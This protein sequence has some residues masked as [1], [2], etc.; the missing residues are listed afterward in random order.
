MGSGFIGFNH[1]YVA[2]Q[3]VLS[4]GCA[5]WMFEKSPL[6]RVV[7]C[8]LLLVGTFATG[9]RGGFIVALI[10]VSLCE[11]RQTKNSSIVLVLFVTLGV[12]GLATS[13]EF[14]GSLDRQKSATN[15][16]QDDGLSGRTDIW[17]EHIDYFRSNPLNLFVG[18]GFGFGEKVSESNAHNLYLQVATESGI[19]GLIIFIYLQVNT[20]RHLGGEHFKTIRITVWMLL[21][22]GLTQDTLYPVPAFSQFIGFYLSTLIVTF[23]IAQVQLEQTT[24]RRYASQRLIASEQGSVGMA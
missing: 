13:S 11:S 4:G 6:W 3:L 18:A 9:S 12:I 24:R 5:Y 1:G 16:M 21:L 20:L 19:V 22:V 7:I 2:M 14:E 8:G 10:F 15:S 17:Q 23:R